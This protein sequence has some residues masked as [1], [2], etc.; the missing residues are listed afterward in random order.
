ME[1]REKLIHGSQKLFKEFLAKEYDLPEPMGK[2][3]LWNDINTEKRNQI[4]SSAMRSIGL[5]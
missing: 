2:F 4:Y 1:K 3:K 5:K